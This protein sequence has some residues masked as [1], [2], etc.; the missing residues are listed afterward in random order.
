M[1]T[2]EISLKL[3]EIERIA[4]FQ[5]TR[6]KDKK[7]FKRKEILGQALQIILVLWIDIVSELMKK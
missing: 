4:K 2:K 3:G 7:A 1:N 5:K 6:I